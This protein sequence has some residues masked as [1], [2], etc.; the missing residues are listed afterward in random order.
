MK[1]ILSF[2]GKVL[3]IILAAF[4]LI[5]GAIQVLKEKAGEGNAVQDCLA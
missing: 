3:A 5:L 2:L 4:I 1:K